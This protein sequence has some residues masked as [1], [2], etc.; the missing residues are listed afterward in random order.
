MAKEM[1]LIS[2]WN[3]LD[4]VTGRMVKLQAGTVISGDL[5]ERAPEGLL[6]GL[7][8]EITNTGDPHDMPEGSKESTVIRLTEDEKPSK[9]PES[10]DKDPDDPDKKKTPPVVKPVTVKKPRP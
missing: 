3:Y 9:S 10:I 1:K 5:L 8:A 6:A 4:H 7:E 2:A